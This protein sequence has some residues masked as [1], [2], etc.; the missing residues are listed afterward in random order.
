DAHL[1]ARVRDDE[2]VV[3][4][5]LGQVAEEQRA[6]VPRRDR[7]PVDDLPVDVGE[8]R[9]H[10][11]D[12]DRGALLRGRRDRDDEVGRAPATVAVLR[13]DAPVGATT[14]A[15]APLARATRARAPHAGSTGPGAGAARAG[16]PRAGA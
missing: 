12:V 16:P 13:A 15:H 14:L 7:E 9:L 8:G 4:R 1:P 3:L 6:P 11:R 10:V 5:P 2:R